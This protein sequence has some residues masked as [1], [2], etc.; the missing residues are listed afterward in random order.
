MALSCSKHNGNWQYHEKPS[1]FE[2]RMMKTIELIEPVLSKKYVKNA[3]K[4]IFMDEKLVFSNN[5]CAK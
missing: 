3:E 5:K 4:T 2:K 1:D